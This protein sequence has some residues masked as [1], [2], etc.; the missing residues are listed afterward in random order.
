[1]PNVEVVVAS[2]GR[3]EPLVLSGIRSAWTEFHYPRR[4]GFTW[5]A[6][7]SRGWAGT[8]VAISAFVLD[9]KQNIVG[10]GVGC[11][12]PEIRPEQTWSCMGTGG[13]PLVK[14]EGRYDVV[15]T[16]NDRPVALWPMEA[17][18][19]S[20]DGEN[21]ALSRWLGEMKKRG[22]VKKGAKKN[23]LSPK[24]P[25]TAPKPAPKR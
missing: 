3:D 1:M 10:R 6:R 22:T 15:F 5:F 19:K 7:G 20:D 9:E 13:T 4:V 2:S 16:I 25:A 8:N 21:S 24:Q 23:A 17:V 12:R 18:V 11:V 14:G